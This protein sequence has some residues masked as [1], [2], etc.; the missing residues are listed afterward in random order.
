MLRTLDSVHLAT[1]LSL[2]GDL[3]VVVAYDERLLS[4]ARD[5]G[6]AASSPR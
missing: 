5:H 3:G 6:L 2:G 4:A 1:A